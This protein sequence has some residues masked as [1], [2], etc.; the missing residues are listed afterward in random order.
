ML[1]DAKV[2]GD[3][4]QGSDA[5]VVRGMSW[6]ASQGADII[7]LSLGAAG[8]VTSACSREADA[9]AKDGIVVVIAAGNSGPKL[10][11]IGSP[12]CA[13]K[14]ITVGSVDQ[15]NKVT[16]Y[17]SRGP[18][19]D[20]TGKSLNKP[21][22][23]APGGGVSSYS[24]CFYAPGIISGKSFDTKDN[25]CTL[26]DDRKVK[27]QK[28][29]GTS[30]ATPHVTGACALLLEAVP[31]SREVKNRC[32]ILKTAIKSSAKKLAYDE[33]LQGAGLLDVPAALKKLK[34]T[35]GG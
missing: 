1:I 27:Y 8:G 7:S 31:M 3:N 33:N 25:E 11:T 32:E 15:K 2:L 14:A 22:I 34:S 21:D 17:S 24:G 35:H 19:L 16:D 30:Q 26:Y 6:A 10:G 18:V 4:G 29:S 23:V 20:L 9:L 12:G 28:M 5:G 13:E